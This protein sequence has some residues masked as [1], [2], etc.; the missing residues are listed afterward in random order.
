MRGAQQAS[1]VHND[2]TIH[3]KEGIK[4]FTVLFRLFMDLLCET[5]SELSSLTSWINTL[6]NKSF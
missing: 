3:S 6:G 4:Y 1:Y 5:K 2:K